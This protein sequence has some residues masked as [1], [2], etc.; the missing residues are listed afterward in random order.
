[1]CW[2]QYLLNPCKLTEPFRKILAICIR[3]I[4]PYK[5][6]RIPVIILGDVDHFEVRVGSIGQASASKL[7]NFR[8]K[9]ERQKIF[10]IT[11]DYLDVLVTDLNTGFAVFD[12]MK[13]ARNKKLRIVGFEADRPDVFQ[14]FRLGH[15]RA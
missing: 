7:R 10:L 4:I 1:M 9:R 12:E 6:E 14:R 11:H 8:G 13:L 15:D 2:K 5:P 3:L